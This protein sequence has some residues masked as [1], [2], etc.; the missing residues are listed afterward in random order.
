[1]W[2]SLFPGQTLRFDRFRT[3]ADAN[4]SHTFSGSG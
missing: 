2:V 4:V 3:D 1:M